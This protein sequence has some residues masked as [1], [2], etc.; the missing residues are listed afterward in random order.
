MAK[1]TYCLYVGALIWN[2]YPENLHEYKSLNP[3]K[4]KLDRLHPSFFDSLL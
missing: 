4:C 3:F 2:Q 1:K